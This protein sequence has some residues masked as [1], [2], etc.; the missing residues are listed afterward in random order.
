[1]TAYET[2]TLRDVLP[3]I[4][5]IYELHALRIDAISAKNSSALLIPGIVNAPADIVRFV[6]PNELCS[7]HERLYLLR[8]IDNI[9]QYFYEA[10][11]NGA[12]KNTSPTLG[13]IVN[14]AYQVVSHHG[15]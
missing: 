7:S 9:I 3:S 14:F 2:Q 6:P 5:T 12:L 11:E 8:D 13:Y 1:M 10:L 15:P 4:V